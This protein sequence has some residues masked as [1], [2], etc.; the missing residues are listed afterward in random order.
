[1][2]GVGMGMGYTLA[3]SSQTRHCQQH[4]QQQEDVE[5]ADEFK[6]T[7]SYFTSDEES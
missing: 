3:S 2:L 1:M 5:P 4:H 6:R 7:N